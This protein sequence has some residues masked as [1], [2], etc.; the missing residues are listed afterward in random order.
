MFNFSAPW[1][2]LSLPLPLLVWFLSPAVKTAQDQALYLPFFQQVKFLF[3]KT[4]SL[5]HQWRPF[6]L[7]GFIW[8]LL[9]FAAAGPTWLGDP[10]ALPQ[11]ARSLMLAVDISGSM[12]IPDMSL[13]GQNISRLEAVQA[14]GQHFIQQRQGDRLGL[15]LFGSKAYL[16]TPLT[17]DHN[18]VDAM[19]QDSSVGLA[20]ELTALGDALGL[21]VKHLKDLPAQNRVLILLTDGASNSG[22]LSPTDAAELAAQYKIKIYTIGFGASSLTVPGFL[23]PRTINPSADLDESSLKAIADKTGGEYFRAKDTGSLNAIYQQLNQLEPVEQNKIQYRPQTAL[24]PWP[25][26]TAFLIA[27]AILLQRA[28][29]QLKFKSHKTTALNEESV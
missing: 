22:H 2:F 27:F 6:I 1:I 9:V 13:G 26:G 25:L 11:E 16:Q 18:T 7:A 4:R 20:G 17:F 19:L 29:P 15:I 12:Q 14:L 10:I 24:Y 21:A 3:H 5:Q 23:G 8:V 28:F